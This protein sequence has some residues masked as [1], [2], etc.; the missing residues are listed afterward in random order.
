LFYNIIVE[1]VVGDI[2]VDMEYNRRFQKDYFISNSVRF[3]LNDYFLM[4]NVEEGFTLNVVGQC[5]GLK[6][7]AIRITE[8]WVE[9]VYGELSATI[10][11]DWGY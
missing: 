10:P 11:D 1:E 2:Y 8:C 6:Y 5:E 4:Q 7:G 9:S 3:Y